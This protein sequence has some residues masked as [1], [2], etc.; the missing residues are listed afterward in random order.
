[1][2]IQI[3]AFAA[4]REVLGASELELE[5]V[6]GARVQDALEALSAEHPALRE[7]PCGFGIAHEYVGPDHPLKDEDE[8]AL[9]P[10]VGGG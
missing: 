8:L 1:M 10:P 3:K 7:I 4:I 2:K 5:L 6:E 9:L